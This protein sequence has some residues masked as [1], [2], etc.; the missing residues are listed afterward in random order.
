MAL[1]DKIYNQDAVLWPKVSQDEEG[2]EKYG[3]A[4]AIKVRWEDLAEE[5]VDDRGATRVSSSK[6]YVPYA[7]NMGD[8][9]ALGTK[10]DMVDL[11]N[12]HRSGAKLVTK[13]GSIPN[14]RATKY[15]RWVYL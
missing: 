13:T 7:L 14:R 1:I 3:T 2:D 10:K 15:L 4:K 8:M 5:Y 11:T 9:I 6:V 12:P